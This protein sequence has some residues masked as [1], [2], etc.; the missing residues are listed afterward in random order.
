MSLFSLAP[1]S[2]FRI[3]IYITVSPDPFRRLCLYL[4]MVLVVTNH[5]SHDP[6][7]QV[8]PSHSHRTVL[9]PRQHIPF[10]AISPAF[11]RNLYSSY[12]KRIMAFDGAAALFLSLQHRL[13]Y[14]VM[15]LARFNLYANSYDF[16]LK[17][18]RRVWHWYVEIGAIFAF[19]AWYGSLLYGIG[20]WKPALVYLLVSHVVPSPL[21]VQVCTHPKP[22]FFPLLLTHPLLHRSCSHTFRGQPSTWAHTNRFRTASYAPRLMSYVPPH[23]HSYTGAYTSR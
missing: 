8:C 19:W 18:A 13:F 14:I 23:S 3:T 1:I 4:D 6:D 11:L 20:N 17:R 16:L 7:I 9:T 2:I 15:S 12:Y 21:H 22:R 5:P 10:F